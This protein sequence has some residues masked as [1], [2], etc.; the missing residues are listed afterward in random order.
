M[1]KFIDECIVANRNSEF[2][3]YDTRLFFSVNRSIDEI[4][5]LHLNSAYGEDTNRNDFERYN[6]FPKFHEIE[7]F[8]LISK[9][10]SDNIPNEVN[11]YFERAWHNYKKDFSSNMSFDINVLHIKFLDTDYL[12]YEKAVESMCDSFLGILPTKK[13]LEFSKEL[14]FRCSYDAQPFEFYSQKSSINYTALV[15]L[16]QKDLTSLTFFDITQI[17]KDV[18][19]RQIQFNPFF[20]TQSEIIEKIK[21]IFYQLGK[22]KINDTKTGNKDEKLKRIYEIY[23]IIT[24][25]TIYFQ[26]EKRIALK[27]SELYS[28]L[29]E[30]GYSYESQY[31]NDSIN[32]SKHHRQ[33]QRELE[34]IKEL[35][36][37]NIPFD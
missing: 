9:I 7:D 13:I 11:W 37:I 33:I 29:I 36:K 30:L 26:T 21:K 3:N 32:A 10:L 23:L 25:P 1:I 19:N 27:N 20:D 24:Y 8:F 4:L 28:K 2:E 5:T 34:L 31:E 18:F 12:S 17:K 22:I 35:K 16:L 15:Y 6:Y 14:I